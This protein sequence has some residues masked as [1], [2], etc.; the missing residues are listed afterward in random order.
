HLF[1]LVEADA[2]DDDVGDAPLAQRVFDHARLAV[3][4]VEDG[5]IRVAE[6]LF[7]GE[8]GDTGG[9]ELRLV[10]LVAATAVDPDL[11][12][13]VL[14]PETLAAAIAVMADHRRRRPHH[15]ARG[16]KVAP[17]GKDGGA[18]EVLLEEEKVA[19]LGAAPGVDRLVVVAD[20]AH[21]GATSRQE[22]E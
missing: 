9:D 8:L 21:L 12:L 3:G 20:R 5:A 2:A 15:R 4:A 19:D 7:E 6:A 13:G 10:A 22:L 16:A 17:Q 11:T 1:A 18:R 14:G